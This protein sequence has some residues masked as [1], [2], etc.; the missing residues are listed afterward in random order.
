MILE[1][2]M[3]VSKWSNHNKNRWVENG[4]AFTFLGDNVEVKAKH[5][6]SGSRTAVKIKCDYC[7]YVYSTELKSRNSNM[8]KSSIK[9]DA[10]KT[11][12]NLK[13]QETRK[14]NEPVRI[15]GKK[16][17]NSCKEHKDANDKIFDSDKNR[18]D[19]LYSICK[20]CRIKRKVARRIHEDKR[21]CQECDSILNLDKFRVNMK[22]ADGLMTICED[23]QISR[24]GRHIDDI[25]KYCYPCER[26]LPKTA[27]Y[28][29]EDQMCLDGFR[30]K[31]KECSGKSFGESDRHIWTVKELELLK[32][33]YPNMSNF[34]IVEN[35]FPLSTE[36]RIG[37]TA[38]KKLKILKSDEYKDTALRQKAVE[39][40]LNSSYHDEKPPSKPQV[41]IN[42]LLDKKNIDY[43]NESWFVYYP[44]DNY[45][46]DSDLI[47]EVHGDYWHVNP[48]LDIKNKSKERV[49][50]KD[51]GKNTFLNRQYG[52]NPLYLW[53][54]DINNNKELCSK[55][56]DMY[57]SNNGILPNYHSFNYELHST[58]AL[59]KENLIEF[60]Y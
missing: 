16:K 41:L 35:Y 55:L 59:I 25:N 10:C 1:E 11:C 40:V 60:P 15:E 21:I 50:S 6:S 42:E 29:P 18:K 54:Y 24:R 14:Y 37:N 39:R 58:N 33:I 47:I 20:E 32:E 19:G 46:V 51:R 43:D 38:N 12:L 4:Y 13:K 8:K 3:V 45:L 5:L 36:T 57:I 22:S 9:K 34:D 2:E 53:E 44:V 31:C 48:T 49:L 30:N 23:C 28:F 52:I 27:Y 7:G 56:I 17:C 26:I